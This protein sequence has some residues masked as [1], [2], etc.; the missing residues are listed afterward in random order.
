MT[1]KER[2]ERLRIAE[3]LL[4]VSSLASI[5]AKNVIIDIGKGVTNLQERLDI[6]V[7][8]I[9]VKAAEVKGAITAA[10]LKGEEE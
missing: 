9:I 6:S 8:V 4:T 7:D 2:N 10:R 3:G 1:S 5:E